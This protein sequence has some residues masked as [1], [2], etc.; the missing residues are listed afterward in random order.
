MNKTTTPK[1]VWV[2]YWDDD[3]DSIYDNGR[4]AGKRVR[5]L[6][7][8]IK[9][10]ENLDPGSWGVQFWGVRVWSSKRRVES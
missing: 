7:A 1:Y 3:V 10:Q 5:K 4:A 2:V 6:R 8:E 9:R